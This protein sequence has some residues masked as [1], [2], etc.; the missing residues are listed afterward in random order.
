MKIDK[1]KKYHWVCIGA[2]NPI[3]IFGRH[4]DLPKANLII[5][6]IV[7]KKVYDKFLKE[8]NE[9]NNDKKNSSND[10]TGRRRG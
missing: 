2:L 9:R 10:T 1:R 8:I 6:S 5:C 3:L 7:S 4:R